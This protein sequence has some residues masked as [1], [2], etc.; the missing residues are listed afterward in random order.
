M[1]RRIAYLVQ[2]R[3]VPAHS[4]LATTFTRKA[5]GNMNTKLTELGV[6]GVRVGTLHSVAYEIL[7]KDGRRG[8]FQGNFKLKKKVALPRFMMG[9]WHVLEKELRAFVS[10]CKNWLISP[11]QAE[12]KPTPPPVTEFYR[13]L[14]IFG[15]PKSQLDALV[16]GYRRY[17]YRRRKQ[18]ALTYDDILYQGWRVLAE[19]KTARAAWQ[20]R[21]RFIIIDECFEGRTPVMLA[22]GSVCAIA[23]LVQQK[24]PG[25][26]LSYDR[27]QNKMVAKDIVGW[28]RLPANKPMVRV[29]LRRKGPFWRKYDGQLAGYRYLICTADQEV[30]TQSGW[31]S[32]AKLQSGDTA[33]MESSAPKIKSYSLHAGHGVSGRSHLANLMTKKNRKGT[34]GPHQN[35][36]GFSG[37][38]RRGNGTGPT[39]TEAEALSKLGRGWIWN[40]AV[41][42]KNG[43]RPYHYKIDVA[44]PSKKMAIEIDGRSH[45]GRQVADCRKDKWLRS[46]GWRLIRITNEQ[47]VKLS[48][49]ELLR[50]LGSDNNCPV[51]AKIVRVEPWQPLVRKTEDLFVYDLT[52]KDTH[53]FLADGIVVHNCQDTCMAQHEI[54][55]LL[56]APRNNIVVVGDLDQSL[57]AFR[58]ALPRFMLEFP[59]RYDAPVVYMNRNYRSV[60][61]ICTAAAALITNNTQR[62]PARLEATRTALTTPGMTLTRLRRPSDEIEFIAQT[63]QTLHARYAWRDLAVLCRTNLTAQ[64][65]EPALLSRSIPHRIVSNSSLLERKVV[66]TLVE[67]LRLGR[68]LYRGKFDLDALS[69]TINVPRRGVG[70]AYLTKLAELLKTRKYPPEAAVLHAATK[71]QHDNVDAYLDLVHRISVRVRHHDP[72]STILSWV[73][74]ELGLPQQLN[75]DDERGSKSAQRSVDSLI[76]LADR[77]PTSRGFLRWFDE[78]MLFDDDLD[79]AGATAPDKVFVGTVHRSKGLEFGAVCVPQLVEGKLPHSMAGVDAAGVEEERRLAYVAVTRA[80]DR[81]VLSYTS[82]TDNGIFQLPSR[83]LT[84]LGFTVRDRTNPL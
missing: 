14:S 78:A 81:A 3:K 2:I 76:L 36:T 49:C 68:R 38:V 71:R 28:H 5:A 52:I 66:T 7:R 50:K 18:Q 43:Q 41:A 21:Y 73:N 51:K 31:K 13:R 40:H 11:T 67:Y 46:H 83:F 22:D 55:Q 32:A 47:A 84:E 12:A 15:Q 33:I 26:V 39:V 9:A 34:C 20:S 72:P 48:A 29:V 8:D 16:V 24:H 61:S 42:T 56:A 58:A 79:E 59:Q 37:G 25:P 19:D 70:A 65:M 17:E 44:Q 57:Y 64:S 62:L 10:W 23:D 54:M 82:I 35:G 6:K 45:V 75:P 4:I 60:P 80:K 27:R 77:W 74:T 1:C 63:L 69:Q 30:L 53:T